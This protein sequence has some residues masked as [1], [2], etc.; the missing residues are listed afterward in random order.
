MSPRN[1]TRKLDSGPA[2]ATSAMSRTRAAEVTPV[3]RHGPRP[4]EAG[5]DERQR[6]ER[7]DVRER[8][9]REPAREAG[10][11]IAEAVGHPAVGDLV[12]RD[13]QQ[14]R[15]DHEDELLQGPERIPQEIVDH[16]RRAWRAGAGRS[17][18]SGVR[19]GER[20][21]RSRRR[22]RRPVAGR[23]AAGRC[24]S[25][26]E[27]SSMVHRR[28][29]GPRASESASAILFAGS[30]P[31][32]YGTLRFGRP[33]H[34]RDA[35]FVRPP[36]GGGAGGPLSAR[37]SPGPRGRA[38]GGHGPDRRSGRPRPPRRRTPAGARRASACPT[39][40]RSS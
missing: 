27:A 36:R 11:R 26:P 13:R 34:E 40:A 33:L 14:Q 24:A 7:V 16:A 9:E 3:D 1:A 32:R 15:R 12:D 4:P 37:R 39:W 29:V 6:P 20:V 19:V 38:H 35:L 22:A 5:E 21:R 17:A 28:R 18:R 23:A 31:T 8:I 2:A 10:G 25:S 30:R